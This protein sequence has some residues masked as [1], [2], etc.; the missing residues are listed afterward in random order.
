M[1]FRRWLRASGRG[2]HLSVR[3]GKAAQL[4]RRVRE[5]AASANGRLVFE[6]DPELSA[7]LRLA[8]RAHDK[9]PEALVLTR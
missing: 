9:S 7:E 6:V 5:D 8:A 4:A 2:K 3:R 1:W